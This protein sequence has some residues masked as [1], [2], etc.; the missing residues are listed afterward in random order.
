MDV[1]HV[2]S[3][4]SHNKM[5]GPKGETSLDPPSVSSPALSSVRLIVN[6]PPRREPRRDERKKQPKRR[7]TT[8]QRRK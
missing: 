4:V 8:A 7:N 5:D 1:F 2:S 6:N 3:H